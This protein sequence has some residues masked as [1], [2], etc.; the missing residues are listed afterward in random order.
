MACREV[1]QGFV[2]T[3]NLCALKFVL[4]RSVRALSLAL[5]TSSTV[6]LHE[7]VLIVHVTH[8]V[9]DSCKQ[10]H[11]GDQHSPLR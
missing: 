10:H 1:L 5:Y 8:S 7:Q 3:D 4:H 2:R 9:M 11:V 6:S